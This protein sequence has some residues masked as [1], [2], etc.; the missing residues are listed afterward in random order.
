VAQQQAVDDAEILQ[1]IAEHRIEV[2]VPVKPPLGD[3]SK[4]YCAKAEDSDEGG[5]D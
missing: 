5:S 1:V 3:G 4:K 2:G